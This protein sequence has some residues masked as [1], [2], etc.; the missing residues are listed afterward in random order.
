MSRKLLITGAGGFVG[1]SIVAQAGPDWHVH[2]L[3][4]NPPGDAPAPVQWHVVNPLDFD[5]LGRVVREI[6][7]H[8]I[9]HAAAMADIDYCEAHREEAHLVNTAWTRQ[10]ADLAGE[11][12]ARLVY[13]STDNAFAGDSGLYT[14]EDAPSPVNYYGQTKVE[15]EAIVADARVPWSIARVS[16]VMGLPI[17]GAG[18]SFLSRMIA[19]FEKGEPV[20]VPPVEVRSPIDLVTLGRALLELAG[21]GLTGI[22]H[23]SGNDVMNRVDFVRRI[24]RR[25]GYP[26]EWVVIHD[27]E[28]VP[29]RGPRPRDVSLSNAKARQMLATPMTGID[30]G[31]EL[32]LARR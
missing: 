7:P 10:M 9:L 28:T 21:S 22:V 31:L 11:C 12:G 25:L 4:R 30:D 1:G 23:L 14:E 3:T 13:V 19:K 2:A 18:N 27:P 6:D 16:I 26:E 29:G 17:L 8:V 32:V 5:A 20:G 15:G 24:A